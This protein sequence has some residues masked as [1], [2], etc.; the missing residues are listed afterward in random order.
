MRT[1]RITTPENIDVEYTLADLG[2][3]SAAVAI[4]LSI[5]SLV[6]LLLALADLAIAFGA[7]AFW[8][9]RQGAVVGIT[10]IL[11]VLVFYGYFIFTEL[12][13]NGQ[14][15]G[16]KIMGIRVIRANG[17]PATLKH[18]ALRNLFKV[19]LDLWGVGICM[20]F[21]SKQ[22]VRLGDI[23]ASTRVVVQAGLDKP[24]SLLS[25]DPE[26]EKLIHYLTPEEAAILRSYLDR[27]VRMD[28]PQE[29]QTQIRAHL[30]TRLESLG[31]L[32]E[33]RQFLNYL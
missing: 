19:V 28:R 29:L 4:D 26:L 15:Y 14:T 23:L 3:R 32:E 12:S 30:T 22:C 13:M 8:E 10:L 21:F 25:L 33:Y 1:F 5:M 17:Q 7:P 9:Q 24:A 31:I 2:S 11:G 27:R 18:L 16:K 6:F 20:I